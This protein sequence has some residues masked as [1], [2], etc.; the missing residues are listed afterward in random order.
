MVS[1]KIKF[2]TKNKSNIFDRR[3]VQYSADLRGFHPISVYRTSVGDLSRLRSIQWCIE[4][5]VLS[6]SF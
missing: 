2:V 6:G 1:G 3:G 5:G 4:K